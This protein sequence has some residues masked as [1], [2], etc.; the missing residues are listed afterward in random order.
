MFAF[1]GR[2]RFVS[3]EKSWSTY[4]NTK[5]TRD[6]YLGLDLFSI[7]TCQPKLNPSGDPVPLK[8]HFIGTLSG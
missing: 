6:A 3:K 7:H 8:S 2:N 4:K 5:T 1:T